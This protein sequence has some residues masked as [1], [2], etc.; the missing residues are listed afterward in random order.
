[1]AMKLALFTGGFSNYPI[2]RAFEAAAKNGYDG[3]EIGGFRPHAYAPDLAKGGAKKIIQLSKDYGLPI[4]DY[5]PENTGSPYSLI[6]EDKEMNKE[7]LEYFKLS[8][9]MAKEINADYCMLACNHPGYGRDKEEV[10]KLFI[11]NMCILSEYAEKIGQT[12]ILEPVT[13]YEGTIIV[14][15]DDVK[16]ALDQVD[17]PRFK[18]MVDLAAPF[19]YGEPLCNYFEKMGEDVKHIHFVDCEKTSEDHLIPGDGEMDFARIVK[20]LKE[21]E[22]Q[23]YL[24]LELFSRYADESDYSAER[25]YQVIRNLLDEN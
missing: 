8:L 20:Y 25:G 15:A 21:V 23:G 7:S 4:C 5:V 17:S 13:P 14:S 6:F 22:Y 10:K 16:W 18:C 12:I 11:E 24:S 3:I 1:M 2:E 19:T 9:D